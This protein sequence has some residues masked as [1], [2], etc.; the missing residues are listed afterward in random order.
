MARPDLARCRRRLLARIHQRYATRTET[1]SIGARQIEFTLIAEPDRVLDDAAAA[2]SRGDGVRPNVPYWAELWD[3][4]LGLANWIA[5]VKTPVDAQSTVLD[6][7][8]GMGLA[9]TAAAANGARVLF[10]DIEPLALLLARLNALPWWERTEARRVDWGRDNLGQRF[11]LIIGADILYER[12]QWEALDQFWR[13]HLKDGGVILLGEPGRQTGE[14]FVP[15]IAE[16]GWQ[17]R[18]AAQTIA[19]RERPIR[20]FILQ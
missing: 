10:A 18:E 9:G 13:A 14:A 2:E 5:A 4:A 1:L 12:Q 7:G 20:I 3:S 15:W 6:L 11:D 17:L 16:R 8:C 19:G